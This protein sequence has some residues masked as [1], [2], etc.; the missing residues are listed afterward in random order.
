M[1]NNYQIL[2]RKNKELV[3]DFYGEKDHYTN[4]GVC[5]TGGI[6]SLEYK[7]LESDGWYIVGL[8]EKTYFSLPRKDSFTKIDSLPKQGFA[9]VAFHNGQIRLKPSEPVFS[10]LP[11]F[12]KALIVEKENQ[13][14]IF[15]NGILLWFED[16][17]YQNGLFKVRQ[18]GGY[19]FYA[20]T[21]YHYQDISD[22]KFY[23]ARFEMKDGRSGYVDTEGHEYFD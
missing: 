6:I 2:T 15:Y 3:V 21:P 19:G 7:I 23:L 13:K 1:G 18:N 11:S 16:V 22:F 17:L 4:I 8:H 20:V 5:G 10:I 9:K 12:E 14:G